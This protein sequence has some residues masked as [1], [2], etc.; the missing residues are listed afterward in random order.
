MLE[1]GHTITNIFEKKK[2]IKLRKT[3]QIAKRV[4]RSKEQVRQ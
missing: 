3:I 2:N 4:G 1:K